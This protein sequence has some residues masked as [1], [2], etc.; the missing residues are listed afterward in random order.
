M[1]MPLD[2]DLLRRQFERFEERV[3]GASGRRFTSFKEGITAE[4]E[5]YKQHLR[6][7]ALGG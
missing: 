4:W 6:Q 2:R 1:D 3:C 5:G 7:K